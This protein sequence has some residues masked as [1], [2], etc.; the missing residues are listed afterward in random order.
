MHDDE[1][2]YS[3]K[4]PW[5]SNTARGF[6]IALTCLLIL[7]LFSAFYS[8]KPSIQEKR[9]INFIPVEVLNFGPGDGSG[10][11]KGNLTKEGAAM[12][13]AK[14]SSELDD[15]EKAGK[16]V[17]SPLS[18]ENPEDAMNIIASKLKGS[19][20]PNPDNGGANT[21]SIGSLHGSPD[22]R[23]MG[24]KGYD[25]GSGQGLGDIEWGGGGNRTVLKKVK[26]YFPGGVNTSGQIKIRFTVQPDGS[27]S[28]MVPLQKVD[29][30][31]ERAAMEA[32]RQWRF[33]SLRD[34]RQMVGIIT[35]S[36]RL[37]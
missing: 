19:E 2:Y 21:K 15:A 11:S 24:E 6:G 35:F 33:N 32:L 4:I 20:K 16:T 18:S 31:L 8:V 29:P 13:G 10:Y 34:Q 7:G 25:G 14:P 1:V 3:L 12:K 9:E 26:P 37:S 5:D 30:T 28:S 36:F 22:G 17:K 27:V 23:G